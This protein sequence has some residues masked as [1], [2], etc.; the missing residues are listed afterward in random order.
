M[1][2][3]TRH[4][5]HSP[6]SQPSS[7]PR[8][9]RREGRA[10]GASPPNS[11]KSS[12]ASPFELA[13]RSATDRR[14]DSQRRLGAVWSTEGAGSDKRVAKTSSARFGVQ[15]TF[16]QPVAARISKARASIAWVA[17]TGPSRR[18]DTQNSRRLHERTR[19]AASRASSSRASIATSRPEAARIVRVV[20]S[21]PIGI[22]PPPTAETPGELRARRNLS[23]AGEPNGDVDTLA[24]ANGSAR[25]SGDDQPRPL[26]VGEAP[27]EAARMVH[28][29]H[30]AVRL[31]L[32]VVEFGYDIAG[33]RRLYGAKIWVRTARQ[34]G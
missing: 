14:C 7:N 33:N 6:L 21:P 20:G 34:S 22:S 8:L 31:P 27:R 4:A 15:A 1:K 16:G 3:W 12:V 2:D 26:Q 23:G 25:R 19:P 32:D 30:Q 24:R 13:S 29:I 18:G 28:D 9:L 10:S 11:Q 17:G 5:K